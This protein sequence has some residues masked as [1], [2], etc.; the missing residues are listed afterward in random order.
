MFSV[1]L[2]DAYHDERPGIRVAYTMG[3]NLLNQRWMHFQSHVSTTA[4]HELLSADDCAINTTSEGSM[5]KSMDLFSTACKTFGLII[6]M[7]KTVVIYRPSPNTDHNAP[8]LSVN[9]AQ[10]TVFRS[11]KIDD[12]VARRISK[13]SQAFVRLQSTIWNCHCLQLNIKL[14]IYE[15]VILPTLLYGAETWTVHKMQAR[16][17]NYFHLSRLRQKPRLRWQGRIPDTDVLEWMGI[18]IIYVM[19]RPL[20]LCRSGHLVRL[21]SKNIPKVL[22]YRDVATSSR[23]QGGQISRYKYTL[24]TFLKH[25]KINPANWE[26][27]A[28]D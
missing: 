18:L 12:E 27:L 7:E 20:Q 22:F 17:L 8:Q 13:V 14:K 16:R 10:L 19:L 24:K 4:V 1:I 28:R 25:L 23:R 15:D 5:Q 3:G 21:D 9:D 2:M 6:N 11:I 26:E